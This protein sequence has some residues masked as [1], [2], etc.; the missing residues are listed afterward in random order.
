MDKTIKNE[1]EIELCQVCSKEWCVYVGVKNSSFVF[2][3]VLGEKQMRQSWRKKETM[4][5]VRLSV[6]V[7]KV[8]DMFYKIDYFDTLRLGNSEPSRLYAQDRICFPIMRVRLVGMVLP[9][10]SHL[11]VFVPT[12]S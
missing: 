5:A 8:C 11:C 12:I 2:C 7:L 4:F 6:V 1:N 9:S 10:N 3:F